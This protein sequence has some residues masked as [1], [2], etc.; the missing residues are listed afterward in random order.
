M[1]NPDGRLDVSGKIT[2]NGKSFDGATVSTIAFTSID[3]PT[4]E[5]LMTTFN[6]KTGH[7]LLTMQDGLK[8]GKYR[9][10]L[11]AIA[12]YDRRT[13]Q[14]SVPETPDWDIY[15]VVLIPPEFN[16]N[17]TIEF[18]VVEGKK[19]VFDFDIKGELV[20]E[21]IKIKREFKPPE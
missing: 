10:R 20:F 11:N 8:P 18:E 1:E 16:K 2:L 3:S 9:V 7:Y 21:K 4:N 14:P 6:T 5:S 12:L 15:Q 17:S 13:N 19:N